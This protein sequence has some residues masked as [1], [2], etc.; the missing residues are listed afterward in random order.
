MK[1]LFFDI[2][3]TAQKKIAKLWAIDQQW[4][5]VYDGDNVEDFFNNAKDN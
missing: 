1:I 3:V 2:E 5:T 4:N